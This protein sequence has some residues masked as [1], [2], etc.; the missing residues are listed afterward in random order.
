M[1]VICLKNGIS[2]RV[3]ENYKVTHVL[4]QTLKVR[5]KRH[6]FKLNPNEWTQIKK[7]LTGY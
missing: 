4:R 6:V 3:G 7:A 2:Y 1:R 5:I